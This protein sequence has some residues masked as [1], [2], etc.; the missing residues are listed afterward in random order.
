ML[1]GLKRA[2]ERAID[3]SGLTLLE[4]LVAAFLLLIVMFGLMQFYVRG[5]TQLD[6]EEDRRKATA[7]AQARLD[8][9][10]RGFTYDLLPPLNGTTVTTTSDGRTYTI[11]HAVTVAAPEPQA[12]TVTL[13]VSWNAR[14]GA[15]TVQRSLVTTTILARGMP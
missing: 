1:R 3:S 7:V 12:T 2:R 14:V 9:L 5:R 10:R 13:T 8:V 4:V 6:Y 15:S 11:Q